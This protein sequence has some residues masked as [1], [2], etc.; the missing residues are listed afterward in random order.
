M[1]EC[2]LSLANCVKRDIHTVKIK[3]IAANTSSVH[4]VI[5][6]IMAHLE[7]LCHLL[8]ILCSM[9]ILRVLVFADFAD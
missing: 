2:W 9:K 7:C 5:G 8:K 1:V 6:F 4:S 3:I